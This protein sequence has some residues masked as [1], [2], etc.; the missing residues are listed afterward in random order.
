MASTS[1]LEITDASSSSS[2]PPITWDVFLSFYGNDTRKN[3]TSHLY[4]ALDQAGIVTFQDDPALKK[5]QEISSG[6]LEAIRDSK[7]FVLIISENYA[8]SPWCLKELV[9]ILSCKK[10]ENQVIPVFYYVDP[11]DVRHQKGSFGDALDYHYQ[12]K[13]YSPEM[14]DEWKSAL[15]QIAALS[16][17]HLKKEAKEKESETIQSIVENIARKVSTKV[18]HVGEELFGIDSAVEE[19]YQKLRMESNDVRA[20][21]ICGMGGIGKTTTAKAFYNKY[22]RNFDGCCFIENVKQY[23]LGGSPLLPLIEKLLNVLLELKDYKVTDVN[24]GIRQLEQ[25][26]HFKKT[27]I[28]LDDL[29]QSSYSEFLAKHCNLFSAGSRIV[30]TSRNVHLRNQL[31]IDLKRVELYM[32]NELGQ[33]DSLKLFNYH[34]FGEVT[35][36]ASLREL[37]LGFVTYSKGL[38]LALKVLGSSLRGRN[39][40]EVFWKTKLE[41]VRKIPENKILEILQLSYDELDDEI[42]KSIFRDIAF[43]FVGKYTCDAEIIFKSC[44]YFPEAGIKILLERCLITIDENHKFQMHDLIQDM[45]TEISKIKRLFLRAN[46]LEYLQNQEELDKIEGLVLDLTQSTEKQINSQIFERLPKLRLLEIRNAHGIKGHFKNSFQELRCIYWSYCTWTR[47]PSSFQPQKLISI[48][49]PHSNFK[50]LWD[51]AMPFR[52]L[53]MINVEYSLKLKTTPNFGNSKSIERLYFRGC[54]SLLKVHPSIR[55]LPGLFVLD[56][57]E[58][59]NVKVSA[60]TLGQSSALMGFLYLNYCSNLRQLPK[61]LGGMK[62]LKE[63]D[64]SYTAIEEL[65]DSITQLKKLVWLKLDGC[66]KLKKLPERIGNMEGLRTFLAGGTAIEQLPDSFGDLIN[67]ELLDLSCCE[68]LRYLPNSVCKLKLLRVLNLRWCSKL[69]RLP[70]KLEMMQF[71][72]QLSATGTAIEEVPDSIGLLSRLRILYLSGC[73]K[74]KNLPD[75]VWNLPSLTELFIFQQDI[76]GINLPATVNN[77]KLVNLSLNCDVRVWLPVIS[78]FSCLKSLVLTAGDES[79][80]STEPFSLSMLHNLEFLE[81]FNCT[82]FGSLLPEP[83]LNISVL[84]LSRHERLVHLPNLSSLKKLKTLV[85]ERF[86]G[87]ESLSSLPPHLQS[88]QIYGCRSLQHLS[89][90][91]MLKELGDLSFGIFN[92]PKPAVSSFLKVIGLWKQFLPSDKV[93]LPKIAEWISYKS[94]GLSV[95]IDIPTMPADNFLGLALS[96]LFTSESNPFSMK[97]VVTNQTNGT[98]K[99]CLIHLYNSNRGPEVCYVAKCIRGDEISVR[100][101]D[102]IQ[103][104]LHRQTYSLNGFKEVLR[105]GVKVKLLGG[106]VIQRTLSAP[107]FASA[108]NNLTKL[109]PDFLRS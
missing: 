103:I 7:M 102:R 14:I 27:L 109:S 64:A 43:F 99:S 48:Y 30:F 81:L 56:L 84:S 80:S 49:M 18:V 54:E 91:S 75:S 107:D 76:G 63:L 32:V 36:P 90:V 37:S 62:L 59:I 39:E 105:E 61:Q 72:E 108:L 46:T 100:S 2:C 16:G 79:L 93:E 50:M 31:K 21:G 74:L 28:V 45:G 40:D 101:G 8:R 15:A 65:P 10:T 9:D 83:P 69:K 97:A 67:L 53:K 35:P 26:L 23:S 98:S 24:S 68:N 66:K 71:L 47:L 38:P 20:I 41:K 51:D 70:D 17:Y 95:C 22:H 94:T 11:S 3:F 96:V 85:I 4:A 106:H 33:D 88:L 58:C 86:I 34:A 19:I 73:N 60:E 29:D 87:V 77:T 104:V 92:I 12:N 52:G 1:N 42:V 89:D 6:L 78:S 5:G 13:R 57:R 82:N 25:I 55:E 44:D